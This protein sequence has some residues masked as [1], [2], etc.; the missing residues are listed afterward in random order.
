MNVI[1]VGSSPTFYREVTEALRARPEDVNWV[2]S[3]ESF[4]S[5]FTEQRGSTELVVISPEVDHDWALEIART[6]SA[7][8]PP[9]ATV[10]V[11]TS[12][13]NGSLQEAMRA[14]V[15]DVVDLS[16]QSH[17]L[18]ASLEQAMAW[19]NTVRSATN[20]HKKQSGRVI[21]V[22]SSK[23]G[24]GKTFL[25][26][27]LAVAASQMLD[28]EVALVD[29]ELGMGDVFSYFGV[30]A[31]RSFQD[32]L[33]LGS[34]ADRETIHKIGSRLG[35]NLF[36]F[37]SP[38]DPSTQQAESDAVSRSL[39]SLREIFGHVIVDMPPDYSDACLA[40]LESSD[41]ICLI[42][43]L[44]VVGVK[45]LAKAFETL[46]SIGVPHEKFRIVLNRA[47][48]KVGIEASDVEKVL[49]IKV[50]AL[51]PSSRLVPTSLNYGRPVLLAE[52]KSDVSRSI[53]SFADQLFG[54]FTTKR[55]GA[56]RRRLRR[57]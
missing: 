34:D 55:N 40:A 28:H 29:L 31:Q 42:T 38:P 6:V 50:D 12:S 45:H 27:N 23:G 7:S 43:Q 30:E 53:W 33:A 18:R 14:G 11:R 17:S 24:A 46:S 39:Q 41:L 35:E 1:S 20:G 32:L 8:A 22:F 3:A 9:T 37:G 51:V 5:R 10:L 2:Q 57:G 26:S 52:P 44:D 49:K 36:G 19:S 25:A 16:D 4:G 21:S 48:S 13:L 47:D 54:E 15:R 56:K